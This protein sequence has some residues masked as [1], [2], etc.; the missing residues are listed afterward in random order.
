MKLLKSRNPNIITVFPSRFSPLLTMALGIGVLLQAPVVL[1]A[2]VTISGGTVGGPQTGDGGTF[3]VTSTGQINSA[4]EGIVATGT[5]IT[6]LTV[7]GIVGAYSNGLNING[8]ATLPSIGIAG[9][10]GGGFVAV[11]NSGTVGSLTT[12]PGGQITAGGGTGIKNEGTFTGTILN[13][14]SLIGYGSALYNLAGG[15]IFAFTNTGSAS[16]SEAVR[17]AGNI[18]T[19]TNQSGG[20]LS[21]GS[22]GVLVEAS[23]TIGT[24]TNAGAMSGYHGLHS[25]G[26]ITTLDNS[27]TINGAPQ[28]VALVG[29]ASL[30]TFTNSGTVTGGDQ[31]MLANPGTT[32]GTLT[33]SGTFTGY[34]GIMS[35]AVTGTIT[36]LAGGTIA[37]SGGR[38]L[39]Q[40]AALTLLENA[41]TISSGGRAIETAADIGTI[42]NK[43]GGMIQGGRGLFLSDPTKTVTTILNN[44]TI[45]GGNAIENYGGI[46]TLTN[47]AAITGTGDWGIFNGSS[48]TIGT[49]TNAAAG[50]ISGYNGIGLYGAAGTVTNAGTIQTTGGNALRM[51]STGS[52]I[53]FSNSGTMAGGNVVENYGNI[54]TFMNSG[55]VTGSGSWG[56]YHG[57]SSTIGTL[58]NAATGT[59][60]GYHGIGLYGAAGTVTNAGMIQASGGNALRMDST[61]SVILF[62]NSGTMAGGNAVENYG[63]ITTFMNS[64]SVT[65]SGSWGFYHA[66][67]TIDNFTNLATGSITGQTNGMGIV[68][69]TVTAIDNAGRIEGKDN[70]GIFLSGSTLTEL[71][72]SGTIIGGTR[73]IQAQDGATIGTITNAGTIE[74]TD[75][76]MVLSDVGTLTNAA[77]GVIRSTTGNTAL[78]LYG[79]TNLIANDG[80]ISGAGYGIGLY[81]GTVSAI[82]NTGTIEGTRAIHS[83]F[84]PAGTITNSGIVQGTEYGMV[85]S[86][87]TTLTNDA[88]G[89]IRTTSGFSAIYLY[90]NNNLITND[91]LISGNG[92]GI[93][94]QAG[95]STATVTNTGRIEGGNAG[96]GSQAAI[97]AINNS[98]DI[99]GAN[100]GLF[101]GGT[102]DTIYNSGTIAGD[103]GLYQNGTLGTL[104]NTATGVIQGNTDGIYTNNNDIGAIIDNSGLISGG[105]SGIYGYYGIGSLTNHNGGMISGTSGPGVHVEDASGSI[106]NELGASISSLNAAGIFVGNWSAARLPILTNAGVIE[107]ATAGVN[108]TDGLIDKIVNNGVIG[109]TGA[110]SGPAVL[111]GPGGVLGDATG[112]GGAALESTGAGALIDGRIVNQ[113]TI[114]HGFTIENQNV[115]VSAAGGSGTFS[116]GTLDVVHGNLTFMDGRVDLGSDISVTGGAGSVFNEGTLAFSGAR[117]ILGNF[118]QLNVGTL[119]SVFDGPTAGSLLIDGT[120]TFDGLFG[121]ELGGF[122][123]AGGESIDLFTYDTYSGGFSGFSVDGVALTADGPGRWTLGSLLFEEEWSATAMRMTV[124]STLTPVPEP[125]TTGAAVLLVGFGFTIRRRKIAPAA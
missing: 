30:G 118:T 18:T 125:G 15:Q 68:T 53:L 123:L 79:N 77:A 100:F 91:G 20:S 66:T 90:G 65:G 9:S 84:R 33:N 113:G 60:T 78:Q 16:A 31:A 114:Y 74:G 109:Y 103:T 38:G 44:G 115:E 108:V 70:Y 92:D 76:G 4:G 43:I 25:S 52:V 62:S 83:E 93:Y 26:A 37:G 5:T 7:D 41:G 88:T 51:D 42:D 28:G 1:R 97:T 69:G 85:L 40:F 34:N 111:V 107:G 36:N 82:T 54:I 3:T 121:L 47:N 112:A 29:T 124:T 117:T 56:I 64:G 80:L 99:E 46:T 22:Y 11:L 57:A 6:A 19:L 61:G 75:Y 73:G 14:G 101:A 105:R 59:I 81:G 63:N 67:G 8:G 24:L 2:D 95:G 116:G 87:V 98:G 45:E 120:A 27:G 32:I 106:T 110:G 71:T 58:T 39:G 35:N 12:V 86:D 48:S 72:N 21:G 23:G 94:F 119:L 89:V 102:I 122:T 55:S 10:V 13:G 50:T 104:T 49:L 17:N 96:L